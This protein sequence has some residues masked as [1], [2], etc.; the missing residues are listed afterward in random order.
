MAIL[1]SSHYLA[2]QVN[3][4]ELPNVIHNHKIRVQ[5]YNPIHIARDDIG[6]VDSCVVQGLV[7]GLANGFGDFAANPAGVEAVDLEFEVREGG[8][9]AEEDLG[10]EA[11]P[12]EMELDALRACGMLENGEDGS[13]GASE[14]VGVQCHG[15]V[16]L[17]RVAGVAIAEGGGLPEDGDIGGGF[18]DDAEADAGG[19][20]GGGV[21]EDERQEAKEVKGWG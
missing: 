2:L 6:K 12:E 9:D 21:E 17:A 18:E 16:D 15:N 5:V 7:Q 19:G 1:R 3:L 4:P 10:L 11:S 8:F 13:H 20:G 14:V